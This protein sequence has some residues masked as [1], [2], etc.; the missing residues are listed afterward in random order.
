MRKDGYCTRSNLKDKMKS[1][2]T[3][4][5]Q[6]PI[7]KEVVQISSS[8]SRVSIGTFFNEVFKVGTNLEG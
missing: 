1:T 6:T 2:D 4:A 8:G 7:K 3:E 5:F